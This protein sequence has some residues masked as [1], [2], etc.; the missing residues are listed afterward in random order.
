VDRSEASGESSGEVSFRALYESHFDYLWHTAR[1]LG[2]PPRHLDDVVHDIFVVVYRRLPD[3][4]PERPIKP[5]LFG[6]AYRTVSDFRRRAGN[7]NE[8]LQEPTHPPQAPA[9]AHHALEAK[10]ARSLVERALERL[11]P[12]R[13]AV[14]V[15]HEI[16]EI[17][18]PQI[19]DALGIPVNT[20]YSRLRLA[21]E[22]FTAAVRRVGS[23]GTR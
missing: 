16:E 15:A 6:I 20:A 12:D 4:D 7:R 13:R 5:W 10:E 19:A 21:R 9:D 8:L 18:V 22:Q 1:R 3:Y 23:G 11:E 2:V 14:F 17:P